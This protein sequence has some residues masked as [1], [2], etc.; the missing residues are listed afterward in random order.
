MKL[1]H[2]AFNSAAPKEIAAWYAK[3]LGMEIV[4]QR[5]TAP[6]THFLADDSG[7]ITIEFYLNPPD[8][9]PDYASMDPLL[10]HLA[11]VSNDP[12]LDKDR[13][14][15][16][17]ATFYSDQ[18]NP[19]GTRLVMLRDPWGLPLQLCKRIAPVLRN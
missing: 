13:L 4:Y 2:V 18:T 3:N 11:F 14:V 16:A 6:F 17:G 15:A 5:D 9:V 8:R 19:E 10:L 12:T 7:Q 1:E